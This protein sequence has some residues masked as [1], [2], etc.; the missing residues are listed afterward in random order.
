MSWIHTA[1]RRVNNCVIVQYENVDGLFEY[2]VYADDG[3]HLGWYDNDEEA[4]DAAR[5]R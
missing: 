5:Q 3:T 4:E 1:E 2:E